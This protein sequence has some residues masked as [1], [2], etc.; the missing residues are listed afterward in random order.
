MPAIDGWTFALWYWRIC[1]TLAPLCFA[2][3]TWHY[4]RRVEP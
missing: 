1:L 4:L 3:G 2:I